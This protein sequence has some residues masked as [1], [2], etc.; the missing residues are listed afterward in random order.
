MK[1][2][3]NKPKII[4]RQ[5]VPSDAK[6][7]AKIQV[8]TWR[9]TYAGIVADSTLA[10]M[11]YDDR[12]QKNLSILQGNTCFSF[13]SVTIED[14]DVMGF[15][16]GGRIR[17]AI[18]GYDGELYALYVTPLY[19]GQG[20]GKRLMIKTIHDLSEK[21]MEH[22]V[23]WVLSENPS[24]A[25]YEKMGGVLLT[26]KEIDINGQKLKEVAYGFST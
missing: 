2:K 15:S 23:T 18:A 13:V 21:G 9:A 10:A 6:A 1:M 4:I 17:D 3:V 26:E 24:R 8:D 16:M 12:E 11:S 25:F 5:A 22:V 20:I 19:H 7:I 14:N